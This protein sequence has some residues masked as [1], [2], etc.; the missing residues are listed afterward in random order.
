MA[1]RLRILI[2]EDDA[3]MRRSIGRLLRASGFLCAE[4]DS[5]E[6]LLRLEDPNAW[7][8]MV[9]DIYLPGLSGFELVDE[10]RRSRPD[11][12][13]VFVTANDKAK[14]REQAQQM[15]RVAYLAKPFE[16]TALLDAIRKVTLK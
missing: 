6:A 7:D 8:C 5:A 12:P 14:T 3:S 13:A 2:V 4:L 9:T 16:G 10:V 11:M 1:D 15:H